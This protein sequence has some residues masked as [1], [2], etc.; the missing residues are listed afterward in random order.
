[1]NT[2]RKKKAKPNPYATKTLKRANVNGVKCYL[3]A[4]QQ[5]T[6]GLVPNE[7]GI[8]FHYAEIQERKTLYYIVCANDGAERK[9]TNYE[10]ALD[11]F[12]KLIEFEKRQTQ[13]K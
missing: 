5:K 1:M 3:K 4:F 11:W 7:R 13:I 9:I 6:I 2:K 8:E 12:A 10:H